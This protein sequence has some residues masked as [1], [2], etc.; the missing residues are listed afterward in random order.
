MPRRQPVRLRPVCAAS[1]VASLLL[2]LTACTADTRPAGA[3]EALDGVRTRVAA[4]EGVTSVR[5]GMQPDGSGGAWT[6][7][8]VATAASPDLELAGRVAA[9]A[10]EQDDA[11][12]IVLALELPAG[13]GVAAVSVDP[14]DPALVA[15][16]G[17]LRASPLVA[18]VS[19]GR[20]GEG[21]VLAEGTTFAAAAEGLRPLIAAVQAPPTAA[22]DGLRPAIDEG[23]LHLTRDGTAVEL[24]ATGPGPALLGALDALDA[25]PSVT[26]LVSTAQ[27][28]EGERA[29]IQ[30]SSA[31]PLAV[32]TALAA[33]PDEAADAGTA[34]RT[35]FSA[36]AADGSD[37]TAGWL[38]LPLGSPEPDDEDALIPPDNQLAA[39]VDV[40]AEADAIRAFL[41]ASVTATGVP[42]EVTTSSRQCLDEP[43]TQA[44]ASV[45]V[46]VFTIMD[47]A[48]E[49]FAAVIRIWSDAGLRQVDR[50]M[51]RDS[52][53]P[54]DGGPVGLA[55]ASIRGT[56]DGLSLSATSVCVR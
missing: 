5:V 36:S 34:R 29:T 24:T 27:G 37:T 33:T 52:W 12:W 20:H 17:S 51:G 35:A 30:V 44:Q 11:G 13:D 7:S 47:D 31:D 39:P 21:V 41:E 46:P 18:S 40:T 9:A 14:R 53:A 6:G 26:S 32:A 10:G 4:V 45:V 22:A 42:A 43:G 25:D 50:A 1:V 38:G 15:R 16:A 8:A 54:G 49:P 48:D 28:V 55:S 23:R 56:A 2:I 3:Q 19:V